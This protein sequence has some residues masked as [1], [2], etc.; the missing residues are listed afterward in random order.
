MDINDEKSLSTRPE[1]LDE[2]VASDENGSLVSVGVIGVGF[3]VRLRA[4][5]TFFLAPIGA[6]RL[7][8]LLP[9]SPKKKF[10]INSSSAANV[11]CAANVL[12]NSPLLIFSID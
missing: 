8:T 2:E 3:V 9:S 10:S 5:G 4:G 12:S 1:L 7:P 6:Y 11:A